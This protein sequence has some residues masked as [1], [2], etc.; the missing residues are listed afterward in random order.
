M[1]A[2]AETYLRQARSFLL[3]GEPDRSVDLLKRAKAMCAKEPQLLVTVL[4]DLC[5]ACKLAGR[6]E[7]AGNY[8]LQLQA[9]IGPTENRPAVPVSP[10]HGGPLVWVLAACIVLIGTVTV[11]W[12][13]ARNQK[14]SA[15]SGGQSATT[16]SPAPLLS[17]R[18][19]LL[20]DD[21]GMVFVIAQ[22]AAEVD[23]R[24]VSW[25]HILGFGSC[26]AVRSNGYLITNNHV[27]DPG[28]SAPPTFLDKLNLVKVSY[29]VCFGPTAADHVVADVSPRRSPRIDLAIL[30]VARSFA[31]PLILA[32]GAPHQGDDAFVAG[33]PSGAVDMVMYEN[34]SQ[35]QARVDELWR[36]AEQ[37]GHLNEIDLFDPQIFTPQLNKGIV[38]VAQRSMGGVDHVQFDAVVGHG[39]SGGPVLNS[40]NRVIGM[41]T[42]GGPTLESKGND[43]AISADELRRELQTFLPIE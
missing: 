32:V 12:R 37:T 2:L 40:Q 38:S 36:K 33:F 16:S 20:R 43:W 17:P 4:Q 23:G 29:L 41:E 31:N 26:F 42:L 21:V 5:N 10:R 18:E 19:K 9:L 15:L 34:Q 14:L 13:I 30:H 22:Y 6:L 28:D 25:D 8:Y 11:T 24:H 1:S 27:L 7:E 35:T 39:N 3:A